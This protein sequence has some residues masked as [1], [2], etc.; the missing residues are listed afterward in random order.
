MLEIR[1]NRAVSMLSRLKI[2]Y[3]LVRSQQSF[4]ANQVMERSW[5]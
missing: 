4:F 3:T 2:E 1:N 5:R